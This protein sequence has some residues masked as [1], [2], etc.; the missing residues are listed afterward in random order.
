MAMIRDSMEMKGTISI[1]YFF[2]SYVA[3]PTILCRPKSA[4]L[5]GY[6][7]DPGELHRS[8]QDLK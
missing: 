7:A 1:L 2:G 8:V 4:C 5:A 3:L 6:Q